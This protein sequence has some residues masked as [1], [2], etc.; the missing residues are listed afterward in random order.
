MSVRVTDKDI[1]LLGHGSYSGGLQNTE[2]PKNIDLYIL[3]PVGY[4]LKT[5][6]AEALIEQRL[7]N[8]LELHHRDGDNTIIDT[9]M[10]VYQ[11]GSNAPDLKLY[12]LGSLSEW[13]RTTIG[14]KKNVVTVNRPTF[15]SQLIKDDPKIKEDLRQ[16]P[17]GEKLKLYWSACAAQISGNSASLM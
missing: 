17:N 13:G 12:D 14:R 2:L 1:V 16:L 3:P 6:V 8:K 4:T 7:I 5:D 9:P 11:G 10:A 15:L